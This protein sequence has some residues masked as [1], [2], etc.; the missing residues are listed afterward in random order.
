MT[1][2]CAFVF[3][4]KKIRGHRSAQTRLR[5]SFRLRQDHDGTSRCGRLSQIQKY[6]N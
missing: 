5:Q 6:K 2:T 3:I 1:N 4:L